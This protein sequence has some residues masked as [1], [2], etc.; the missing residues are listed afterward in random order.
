MRGRETDIA[1][2]CEIV[3][4]GQWVNDAG[5]WVERIRANPE[6]VWRVMSD[7]KNAAAEGRIKTTAGQMAE[8]NWGSFK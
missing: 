5:K 8:Y 4:N 2:L 3:L 6:K 1:R 7:V